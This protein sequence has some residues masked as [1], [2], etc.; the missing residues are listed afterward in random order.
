VEIKV[1]DTLVDGLV[2]DES[3]TPVPRASVFAQ[4]MTVREPETEVQADRHGRFFFRGLGE[5]R[6]LIHAS[7][8]GSTSEPS[9]VTVDE[10]RAIRDL[11]LVLRAARRVR[12]RVVSSVGPVV[13]AVVVVL[14]VGKPA[15]GDE[16]TTGVDGRFE[17]GVPAW[18]TGLNMVVMAVGHPLLASR[19]PVPEKEQNELIIELPP[20]GG[21]VV[22][23]LPEPPN[24]PQRVMTVVEHNGVPIGFPIVVRWVAMNR[25]PVNT[26]LIIPNLAPGSYR[27][28][29]LPSSSIVGLA[30]GSLTPDTLCGR[31]VVVP[32]GGQVE[33]AIPSLSPGP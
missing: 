9:E 10:K 19:L 6:T 1:P 13:G 28:C 27:F 32:G 24:D 17:A 7:L 16:V 20:S 2:V 11:V 33:A 29:V 25:L 8:E 4:S 12:G 18:A 22:V 5:G 21:T 3:G 23:K 31:E 30:A 15:F 14:P 26:P